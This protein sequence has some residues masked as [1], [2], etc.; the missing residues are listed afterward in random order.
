MHA[1]A[2]HSLEHEQR[3]DE[4]VTA[5]LQAVA[6]GQT[7][8]P[9]TWL[10]RYPELAA[11]L[12]E[13]LHSQE[14]IQRLTA[15]LRL[16][17][18]A[19][20]MGTPPP[21][22][23]VDLAKGV[24]AEDSSRP[25]NLPRSFGGYE[26]L[27]QIGRGGMGVV[28]KARQTS[29]N[30]LVALKMVC[31]QDLESPAGLQRFRQE[32]EVIA[33]LDHPHIVPV[34][35]VG[36]HEGR[37]Y[38]SMKLMEGGS[39]AGQL[40]RLQAEP[41]TAASL[42]VRIA[43]AVH[44]THQRGILHRDLK[45]SNILLDG[46]GQPHVADF[47]LAKSV[48]TD[49]SLASSGAL[50]GT[51]GYMAPEQASGRRGAITTA[52]DVYGLGAVLYALLAGRPPFQGETVLDTL[53]N[54]KE[55]DPEPPSG[56]NRRLDR[57]METICLKCLQKDPQRRYGSAEALAEDLERW[58]K[59]EPILARPVGPDHAPGRRGYHYSHQRWRRSRT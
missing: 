47:G 3:L 36:E 31:R 2:G 34:Y 32:A 10:A 29:L 4:V 22:E 9:Q 39:L 5:Y 38:F 43:R 41:R 21:Q 33:G 18:Q 17:T 6:A 56:R 58:L 28:Y 52:T 59:G 45:P 7:P 55:R 50:V 26:L 40:T 14:Q 46:A 44:H 8:E 54:V 51:P 27:A 37:A 19:A 30:R 15:P 24:P 25:E 57:D 20:L 42:L 23:I 12:A 1:E 48:R 49:H 16:A 35:E 13:F 11:E 53:T